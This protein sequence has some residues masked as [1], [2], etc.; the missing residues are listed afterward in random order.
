[1]AIITLVLGGIKSGKS[2]TGMNCIEQ[3]TDQPCIIA[4]ARRTDGEMG[5][6]IDQHIAERGEHWQCIEA[7]L[8]L[9]DAL[10]ASQGPV[11][12]DC[13]GTWV[14]NLLIE[15]P[16]QLQAE[17]DKLLSALIQRTD[18]TVLISNES[19]LGVIGIDKI[20][21]QF[22]DQLGLLNQAIASHAQRVCFCVAGIENWLKDTD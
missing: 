21:R 10:T 20:T 22:V 11:L 4:T 18:D 19:G 7:P 13:L 6:R 5:Q 16:D 3:I 12:V 1:M 17:I 9:A 2:K 8:A 14:T 15:Q